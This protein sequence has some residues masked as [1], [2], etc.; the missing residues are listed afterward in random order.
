MKISKQIA[1]IILLIFGTTL[2]MAQSLRATELGFQIG[3]NGEISPASQIDNIRTSS[4]NLFTTGKNESAGRILAIV[5][6][7]GF[8]IGNVA[9]W[10]M[11][12]WPRDFPQVPYSTEDLETMNELKTEIKAEPQDASLKAELGSIYFRHN[13]LDK[14]EEELE[15]AIELEPK[16]PEI[17]SW[18][19]ANELKQT[20]AMLDFTWGLTKLYRLNK[21]VKNIDATVKDDPDN[22]IVRVT[23]LS[24][25]VSVGGIHRS[26][27]L[28]HE[29]ELWF[30]K[31]QEQSADYFPDLL[32]RSFYLSL[33]KAH[34][35]QAEID[36]E[37]AKV[38]QSRQRSSEYVKKL[39][40]FNT[41]TDQEKRELA[42]LKL[43][44]AKK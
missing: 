35:I 43:K 11:G 8:V 12:A 34:L 20:G 23:H 4:S 32:K 28:F 39:A 41:L 9:S 44:L 40:A 42:E 17:R 24:T 31:K 36:K 13:E 2:T 6:I 5:L 7:S 29:D 16:N 10:S 30:K 22:A 27:R 21:A 18:Y 37:P 15:Q 25:I 33:A 3:F 26:F 1:Q 38:E 19:Y 14:A